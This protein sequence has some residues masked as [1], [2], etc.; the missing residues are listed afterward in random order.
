M[1]WFGKPEPKTKAKAT[2]TIS[3]VRYITLAFCKSYKLQVQ[4]IA[5]VIYCTC[6]ISQMSFVKLKKEIKQRPVSFIFLFY[7][8]HREERKGDISG[9]N[10]NSQAIW[11]ARFEGGD[12]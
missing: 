11:R 2:Y 7:I 9:M 3:Q 1:V 8:L 12:R 10:F 5:L 4:Y 6:S